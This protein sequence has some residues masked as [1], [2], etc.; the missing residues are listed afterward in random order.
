MNLERNNR[1]KEAL[2]V[3]SGSC[4]PGTQVLI[5]NFD[6]H[7]EQELETVDAAIVTYKLTQMYKID[8]PF[9]I[10]IENYLALHKYLFERVYPFAGKI[11][12]ENIQKSNEP[13]VK[14]SITPFCRPEYIYS[15]LKRVIDQMKTEFR[16][17]KSEE[18]M[19]QRL[20][21]FYGEINIIH[22]FR[23]PNGNRYLFYL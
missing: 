8:Y 10:S 21:Y 14:N 20:A 2:D 22:P 3:Q 13:Y 23:E 6:I 9:D 17:W 4:Y 18:E 11:R 16:S 15:D 12:S 7:D 1:L 5:N 19:I